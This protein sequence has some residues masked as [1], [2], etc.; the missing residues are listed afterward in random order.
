[1]IQKRKA[2]KYTARHQQA[3]KYFGELYRVER[4]IEATDSA[5]RLEERRRSRPVA[6]ALHQWLLQQRQKVP[7]GSATAKAID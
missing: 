1:M 6:D 5:H 4:S 3:L 2:R 7:D